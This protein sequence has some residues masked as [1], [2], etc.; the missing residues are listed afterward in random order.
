M[1]LVEKDHP[2]DNEAGSV[3]SPFDEKEEQSNPSSSSPPIPPKRKKK[4]TTRSSDSKTA[5]VVLVVAIG[6]FAAYI[7]GLKSTFLTYSGEVVKYL[8][9]AEAYFLVRSYFFPR[10]GIEAASV[11]D[12]CKTRK[13]KKKGKKVSRTSST[14]VGTET[15]ISTT[16]AG[17]ST[18]R[19]MSPMGNNGINGFSFGG[20]RPSSPRSQREIH[21]GLFFPDSSLVIPSLKESG[22]FNAITTGPDGQYPY[23]Y[24]YL[25]EHPTDGPLNELI[26]YLMSATKTLDICIYVLTFPCFSDIIISQFDRGVKVRIIVDGRE[27]EA[28]RS[29]IPKLQRRGIPVKSNEKS[30][31]ILMHNKFV[32]IDGRILMTGSLNWTKSAIL[33]NYDNVLVTTQ[34]SLVSQYQTHF[35]HLWDKMKDY[36]DQRHVATTGFRRKNEP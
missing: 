10:R 33:L 4:R 6:L 23:S 21:R 5:L 3:K 20:G 30:F 16:E 14:S 36:Q 31:S 32:I 34:E 35:D 2:I 15:K 27:D 25:K 28:M 7:M 11:C 12:S 13:S 1:S 18:P 9:I 29:Q 8:L 22:G 19:I 26:T 24:E 17:T